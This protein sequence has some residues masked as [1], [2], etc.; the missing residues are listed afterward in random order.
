M[1][2][3]GGGFIGSHVVDALL[4]VARS[5]VVP[6]RSDATPDNLKHVA[7]DI[8]VSV[9]D[10]RDTGH[11]SR[12][13]AGADVVL[14]LAAVVGGIE[15]N[16]AHHASIFRDN[17]AVFLSSMEAA[18]EASVPRVLV[19]SSACVYQ[20]DCSIPT[21]ESEG[22]DGRPEPTNEG[23]GWAKRMEEYLASAYADEYGMSV[24]VARPYNGYGPRDDF[25]PATAHVIP[26]LIRRAFE[27]P[28]DELVVW[29][30]GTQSRSFLYASDFAR[31]LIRICERAP[32]AQPTNVGADEETTI[33][34][35][36]NMV[37]ELSGVDKTVR[38]DTS[39][40]EGQP[41]RHCDTHRLERVFSFR[42]EVPLREGLARTIDYYR[43][44]R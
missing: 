40:P 15:Y 21:P 9:G 30:S 7:S 8:E 41:R 13:F 25:R 14:M 31:G 4:P 36:A 26:A 33:G 28:G 24:A 22:F 38:F 2:T 37:V 43:A 6:T 34:D 27:E 39:R 18:R 42:A 1:V 20:R 5:I 16:N 11:A 19:T 17:I 32:D 29:G 10:L 44:M 12:V 23:Y 3:G 35:V